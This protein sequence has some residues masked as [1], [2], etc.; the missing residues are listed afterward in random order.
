MILIFGIT[1]KKIIFIFLQKT[2]ILKNEFIK[3]MSAKDHSFNLWQ[4][5][6]A[7]YFE[8]IIKNKEAIQNFITQSA[9]DCILKLYV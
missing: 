4:S 8:L 6:N 7:L 2:T 1:Q 5:N 9:E 3:G